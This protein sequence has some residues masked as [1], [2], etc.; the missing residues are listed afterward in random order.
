MMIIIL[1]AGGSQGS[2]KINQIIKEILPQLLEKYEI[3]HL[4]GE[5]DFLKFAKVKNNHYHLIKFSYQVPRLISRADF[6]ITRAGANS[7]ME[8]AAMSRPSVIIPLP[9]A[10]QN[11][12][13][14]NALIFEKDKAGI[15]ILEKD[16]TPRLLRETIEKLALDE[17]L[18]QY[19]GQSAHNF[20]QKDSAQKII[21]TIFQAGK[22]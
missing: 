9:S 13:L 2:S 20:F 17:T 21:K 4:S 1:I 3:Y 5:K 22:C 12:Q 18:R 14:K 16:L 6:V 11:H 8:I 10:A 19:L 7:L 15:V